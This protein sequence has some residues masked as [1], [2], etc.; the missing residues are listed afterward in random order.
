MCGIAGLLLREPGPIQPGRMEE[1]LLRLRP[2]GPDAEGRWEGEGVALGMRRLSIIDLEHGGQP[3]LSEA[4]DIVA[5]VN[6]EIYNAPELR[7][8]LIQ[9]GHRFQGGS[10]CEVLVHLYEEEGEE[11]LRGLRG[12]F[13]FSLWDRKAARLLLGV[14]RFGEKPLHVA[15]NRQGLCWA[16]ELRAMPFLLGERLRVDAGALC[17]NFQKSYLPPPKTL[18]RGVRKLDP[19]TMEIWSRAG[20]SCRRKTYWSLEEAGRQR[21]CPGTSGLADLLTESGRITLRSDRPV[22]VALSGGLDS[23]LVALLASRGGK[24]LQAF[25]VGYPGEPEN[26]ERPGARFMAKQLGIPLHECEIPS[27]Q[28]AEEFP[29]LIEALDEPVADIAAHGYRKIFQ[30][31]AQR[32]I[33]VLLLGQGGDELSWGYDWVQKS[34]TESERAKRLRGNPLMACHEYLGPGSEADSRWRKKAQSCFRNWAGFWKDL[35]GRTTMERMFDLNPEHNEA[36][37]LAN[38]LLSKGRPEVGEFFR[39]ESFAS[40][41]R[42]DIEIT[43][44]ICRTYLA[45]NGL[46]L[47]DRLG[48]ACSV[49]AR[50]PLLDTAWIEAWM[51]C[52]RESPDQAEIPKARLREVAKKLGLPG[53]V[54]ERK[55]RGFAPPGR[56]WKQAALRKHFAWLAD[57]CLMSLGFLSPAGL[58]ILREKHQLGARYTNAAYTLLVLE[59]V[60]RRYQGH[61]DFSA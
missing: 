34:V 27:G 58:R 36:R 40:E 52:R 60:L 51:A 49:E 2:R 29:E 55:K 1:A 15:E 28:V 50:L 42:P 17:E 46:T 25:T 41:V 59:A 47:A 57:G 16:S 39:K 18:F 48:M 53:E 20:W 30:A 5:T 32:N 33:P 44:L 26:D 7:Q 24:N 37:T 43:A 56:E 13:A 38:R 23:S 61:L 54:L 31:A 19:G 3:F 14:D 11:F 4:G 9:R 35:R 12:M 45:G 6:G 10:D 22:G 8:E 21:S